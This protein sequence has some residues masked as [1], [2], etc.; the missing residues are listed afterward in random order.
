MGRNLQRQVLLQ[1]S[2]ATYPELVA[3]Q[4]QERRRFF[5][6]HFVRYDQ[7]SAMTRYW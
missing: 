7:W 6:R 3:P 2:A 1:M 5:L 4:Q